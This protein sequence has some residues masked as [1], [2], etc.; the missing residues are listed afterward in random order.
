MYSGPS[1][2]AAEYALYMSVLEAGSNPYNRTAAAIAAAAAAADCGLPVYAGRGTHS[3]WLAL[4]MGMYDTLE[5]RGPISGFYGTLCRV[6][7]GPSREAALSGS[8]SPEAAVEAAS[9]T[10][11][12]EETP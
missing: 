8:L 4:A 2:S 12:E 7:D 9:Q 6:L 1:A 5:A 11:R 3:A 10:T